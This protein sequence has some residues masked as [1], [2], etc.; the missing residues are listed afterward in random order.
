M[1]GEKVCHHATNVMVVTPDGG[2]EGFWTSSAIGAAKIVGYYSCRAAQDSAL[3][4]MS[5]AAFGQ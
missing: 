3:S 4:A 1:H 2:P 5:V